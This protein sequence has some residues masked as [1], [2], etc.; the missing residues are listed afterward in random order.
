[1]IKV[2]ERAI[3]IDDL[4]YLEIFDRPGY[5]IQYVFNSSGGYLNRYVLGSDLKSL[6]S[7]GD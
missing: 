1:M 4:W 2:T 6:K 5:R 7:L 3:R